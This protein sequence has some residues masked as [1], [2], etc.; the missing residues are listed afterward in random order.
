MQ[1]SQ[2]KK[3]TKSAFSGYLEKRF[4]LMECHSI[5]HKWLVIRPLRIF[6][7]GLFGPLQ[8][9]YYQALRIL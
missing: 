4:S 8:I 5:I 2:N 3:M 1:L 7:F 6:V 9:A